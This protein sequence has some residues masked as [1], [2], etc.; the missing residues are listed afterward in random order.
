[1]KNRKSILVAIL[2]V[3]ACFALPSTQAVSPAPDGG[4]PGFNTAEGDQALFLLFG[5]FANSAF[6][7]RAQF[8]AVGA[9]NNTSVGAGTLVLNTAD[10]NTAVGTAALL[11]NTTGTLNTAVGTGALVNNDSGSN[12]TTVGAF[13]GNN[14]SGGASA[15]VTVGT[16]STISGFGITTGGGNTV[17]GDQAGL[18]I[19]SAN[20]DTIIG[21]SA[22]GNPLVLNECIYIGHNVGSGF[23]ALETNTIRIGDNLPTTAGSSQCFIGGILSHM[24]PIAMNTPVVTIDTT[25]GQLG[26]GPDFSSKIVEQQNKIE[27]QQASIAQLK[28]EMQTMVAQLKDQAAQIQR[29]NAQLQ[30]IKSAP[31]VVAN[32]P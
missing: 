4:Y 14:I 16:G 10:D 17:V 28:S 13:A 11:L 20:N 23:S 3:L 21:N 12:N 18:G 27:E 30:V 2:P 19:S 32:K 9:N 1:M 25:T 6:G 22:G 7:W 8:S 15:N 26:W 29:V 31:Q 5:G 24:V